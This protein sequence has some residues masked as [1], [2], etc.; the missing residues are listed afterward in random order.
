M[1]LVKSGKKAF[2]QD[3]F[4]CD[5]SNLI[6]EKAIIFWLLVFYVTIIETKSGRG[7]KWEIQISE[8]ED[9]NLAINGLTCSDF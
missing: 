8:G 7:G 3:L 9:E 6:P 5:H 2:P 4:D 1:L